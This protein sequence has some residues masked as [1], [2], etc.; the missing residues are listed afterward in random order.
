[1]RALARG[2]AAPAPEATAAPRRCPAVAIAGRAGRDGSSREQQQPPPRPAHHRRLPLARATPPSGADADD[3]RLLLA[4][5]D[6]VGLTADEEEEEEQEEDGAALAASAAALGASSTTA[7]AIAGL[8]TAEEELDVE[9]EATGAAP[10]SPRLAARNPYNA[11]ASSSTSASAPAA[12]VVV[13][14]LPPLPLSQQR[15][16]QLLTPA[17]PPQYP[18]SPELEALLKEAASSS[19]SPLPAQW[20]DLDRLSRLF[21][22]PLDP[23]QA[24]A[25]RHLVEGQARSVVVCAPTGAGK[26]AIAEAAAAHALAQGKRV[27]Y[28]TPLKALSNQKLQE[29]RAFFGTGRVGLQTG[30]TSLNA[31]ADVVVMTTEILRNI[32]YRA[33]EAGGGDEDAE[34][35]EEEG[36]EDD[37][38]GEGAARQRR[39]GQAASTATRGV[40]AAFV[41]DVPG[42]PAAAAA[43][44]AAAAIDALEAAAA[45]GGLEEDGNATTTP[46]MTRSP[47]PSLA[48][49][50]AA[51]AAAA[52]QAAA[53]A[54]RER[55]SRVGL[56]VLDE[57]HYL[58]D[59]NRGSVWEEIIINCPPHVQ[60]LAMSATVKNP[61][62]LGGWMAEQRGACATVKTRFRPVP[63]RWFFCHGE[64]PNGA[65]GGGGGGGMM[66][67]GGMGGGGRR[68]EEENASGGGRGGRRRAGRDRGGNGAASGGGATATGVT[69]APLLDASGKS[70]NP[71]LSVRESLMNEAL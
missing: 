35:G 67:G 55:L 42:G 13:A 24:K 64:P 51:N 60:I 20:P 47:D 48:L 16:Q 40:P 28:T 10:H 1:M 38:Q 37:G 11:S 25:V 59:P 66:G 70:L 23:F 50:Q 21:P 41:V 49:L 65:P 19:S 58:G 71:R 69:M 17:T 46:T 36:Q 27:V 39:G 62:D 22:F 12:G 57:V 14:A 43:E 2:Q 9:L 18:G 54:A 7:P 45:A 5:E 8:T 26:T 52:A 30:D 33:A 53:Q 68:W 15:Q 63:L 32:I 31:D 29:A 44:A 61:D 34:E 3:A 56:V 4:A 6:L